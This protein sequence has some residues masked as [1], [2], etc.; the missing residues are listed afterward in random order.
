MIS[1]LHGLAKIAMW[2][3]IAGLLYVLAQWFIL[4]RAFHKEAEA[5][6]PIGHLGA[7]RAA[8]QQYE[9]KTGRIPSDPAEMVP[10][11]LPA[12]P[13]LKLPRREASTVIEHYGAEVCER[14]E[15]WTPVLRKEALRDTGRWGYVVD[16]GGPCH[17]ALFID[18]TREEDRTRPYYTY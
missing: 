17:G 1:V 3:I 14:I 13:E 4:T 7:L 15:N 8:I 5:K 12:I 10:D 11:V 6:S 18:S 9:E 2:L 16:P